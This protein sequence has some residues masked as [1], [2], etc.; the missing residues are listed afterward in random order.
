MLIRWSLQK[1]FVP[2]PKSDNPG[3][4]EENAGVFGWEIAE[5]EMEVLDG[6]DQGDEGAIVEAVR[7]E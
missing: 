7:N 2:L 3:R 4:I 6:L 1:G 5:K